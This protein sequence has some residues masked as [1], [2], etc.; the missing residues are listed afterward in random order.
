MYSATIVVATN[1]A[2]V[3]QLWHPDASTG[4]TTR[5]AAFLK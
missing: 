4:V 2:N 3:I 1:G 5:I